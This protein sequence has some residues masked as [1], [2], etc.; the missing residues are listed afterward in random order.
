M[1]P[2]VAQSMAGKQR[3]WNS[4]CDGMTSALMPEM[5]IP[6]YTHALRCASTMSRAIAAPAPALRAEHNSQYQSVCLPSNALSGA[7]SI[8]VAAP[9]RACLTRAVTF[10]LIERRAASSVTQAR[11]QDQNYEVLRQTLP[12]KGPHIPCI[13]IPGDGVC[14]MCGDHTY[15]P[16]PKNPVGCAGG[17]AC[18]STAPAAPGTRSSASPAAT[19]SLSSAACTPVHP[20]ASLVSPEPADMCYFLACLQALSDGSK[21]RTMITRSRKQNSMHFSLHMSSCL[22]KEASGRSRF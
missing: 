7:D 15:H 11:L 16:K 12:T 6:A 5:L 3:T 9:C 17:R 10:C 14:G 18:S 1:D 13:F 20:G 19:W 22:A 2:G 21:S 8:S 4:H